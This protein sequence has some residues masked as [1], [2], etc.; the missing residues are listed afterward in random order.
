MK[1]NRKLSTLLIAALV[2]TIVVGSTPALRAQSAPDKK[3]SKPTQWSVQVDKVDP[4]DVELASAFQIAIYENLLHEINKTS[5][6]KQVFRSGDRDAS[7]AANLLILKTAVQKYS[8]G[9]ET[10]RA[11]TTV[12][13]A[14]KLN[15]RTQLCTRDGK[16]IVERVI[17]GNVRFFGSN[18]RATHNLARNIAK[19]IKQSPLPDPSASTLEKSR[20]YK[21]VVASAAQ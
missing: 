19:E 14:T 12:T 8:A 1:A 4:G 9:S 11:V 6:F 3:N 13:G 21:V 7:A 20:A 2:V 18:L 17:N 16:V 15:V 10:K 5:R